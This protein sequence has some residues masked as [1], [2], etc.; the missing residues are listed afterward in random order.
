MTPRLL[1]L[2][3][4]LAI[5]LPALAQGGSIFDRLQI[6]HNLETRKEV[7]QPAFL[8]FNWPQGDTASVA[9]GLGVR[10]GIRPPSADPLAPPRDLGVFGEILRNTDAGAPQDVLRVGLD[11]DAQILPIAAGVGTWSPILL[12]QL[13]YKRDGEA[14]TSSVQGS[15]SLTTVSRNHPWIPFPNTIV[16]LGDNVADFTVA[17]YVGAEGELVW[18]EAAPDEGLTL[19]GVARADAA[20][21]PNV[22]A[23]FRETPSDRGCRTLQGIAQVAY[24][25]DVLSPLDRDDYVYVR[26]EG[27]LYPVQTDDGSRLAG[28]GLSYTWGD[29]PAKG[30]TDRD[31][32]QL[33][34]KLLV[35]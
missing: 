25:S 1:F 7:A 30:V 16:T 8:Q 11:L 29:D 19:R 20:L 15:L 23:L 17:P 28:I 35:K 10:V 13:N 9:A 32:L 26:L 34:L 24:R 31:L 2:S 27:N 21:Y 3:V 22:C 18:T 5:P 6:R 12:S 4:V 14:E 33:T